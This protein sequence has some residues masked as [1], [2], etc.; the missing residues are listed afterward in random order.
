MASPSRS[1]SQTTN[2]PDIGAGLARQWL[3]RDGVDLIIDVPTSSVALAVNGVV[4]ERNK[5]YVNTSAATPD[6]TGAQCSPNTIHW[7]YDTYMLSS[8]GR[9]NDGGRRGHLY[10]VSRRIVVFGDELQRDTAAV[11]T[12]AGGHVLGTSLYPFPGTTD[13]WSLLVSAQSSA[14][15]C[16]ASP[17]RA[18]TR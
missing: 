17:M 16:S 8:H 9:R 18:G 6:L 3:D 2:K 1:W 14:R 15:R 4:R 5:A 7:S 10:L 11:L 13:F 12:A